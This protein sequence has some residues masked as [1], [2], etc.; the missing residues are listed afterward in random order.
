MLRAG[1]RPGPALQGINAALHREPVSS[2]FHAFYWC[3]VLIVGTPV[4]IAVLLVRALARV[5]GWLAFGSS[6][7]ACDPKRPDQKSEM[8]V[9]ITGCDGGFGRELALSA[10]DAG[11]VV[12]AGC[13][14]KQNSWPGLLPDGLIPIQMDVTKDDQVAVAVT[15]VKAWLNHE[16]AK[17]NDEPKKKRV[18]HALINNAGV[19]TGG[20]VDWADLSSFQFCIDGTKAKTGL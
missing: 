18:L 17:A 14:E 8:A 5:I 11:Y 13:L 12:F 10:V 15:T 2:L 20:L 3:L 6:K 1:E 19:G 16:E 9:V 7:G 4:A